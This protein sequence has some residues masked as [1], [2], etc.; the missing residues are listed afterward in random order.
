MFWVIIILLFVAII[1]LGDMV[2]DLKTRV[3]GLEKERDEYV[4]NAAEN[5]AIHEY[6]QKNKVK[7][8]G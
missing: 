6:L 1:Y 2:R 5:K 7:K 3:T 8:R 4:C